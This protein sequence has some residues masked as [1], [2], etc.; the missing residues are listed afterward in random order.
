MCVE[1]QLASAGNMRTDAE[2]G[3]EQ[4]KLHACNGGNTMQSMFVSW[5]NTY[6][7]CSRSALSLGP[8]LNTRTSLMEGAVQWSEQCPR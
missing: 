3:I 7:P 1:W 6:V 5:G 8:E 4:G 2:A